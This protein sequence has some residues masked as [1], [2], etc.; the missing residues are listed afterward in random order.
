M[1]PSTATA[2]LDPIPSASQG[3]G[4]DRY[5]FKALCRADCVVLG[6]DLSNV[7]P[8]LSA[9][10]ISR[11][12]SGPRSPVMLS[13]GRV[14]AG[15]P[16]G[17]GLFPPH[18]S[19]YVAVLAVSEQQPC[20]LPSFLPS[21]PSCSAVGQLSKAAKNNPCPLRGGGSHQG[22]LLWRSW[23][24]FGDLWGNFGVLSAVCHG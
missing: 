6:L 10:S 3:G 11:V 1:Q 19:R 23:G 8:L 18:H 21:L 7:S 17:R 2:G 16:T 9:H 15:C 13:G 4:R 12:R 14:A 20:S 24:W 5:K 22:A